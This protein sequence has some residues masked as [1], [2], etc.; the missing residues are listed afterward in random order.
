[1]K[2]YVF[3]TWM[4]FAVPKGVSTPV[5]AR[6]NS[7]LIRIARLPAVVEKTRAQGIDMMPPQPPAAVDKLVRDELALWVPIIKA[8]GASAE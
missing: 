1:M 8:S 4:G 3:N 5:V 7:E 2:G 6:L